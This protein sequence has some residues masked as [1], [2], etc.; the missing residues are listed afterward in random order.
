MGA[1]LSAP[2]VASAHPSWMVAD[3]LCEQFD[4]V[5]RQGIDIPVGCHPVIEAAVYGSWV[6]GG[7]S[8][9]QPTEMAAALAR[10][11]I[12]AVHHEDGHQR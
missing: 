4:I 1:A 2:Q 9:A 8:R 12:P 5:L 11:T 3:K 7:G 6:G 10:H